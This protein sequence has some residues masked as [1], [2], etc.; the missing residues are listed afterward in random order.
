MLVLVSCY[1]SKRCQLLLCFNGKGIFYNAPYVDEFHEP[2]PGL[3]RGK[4][5]QLSPTHYNSLKLLYF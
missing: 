1:L 5:L 2:D 3:K 4:R